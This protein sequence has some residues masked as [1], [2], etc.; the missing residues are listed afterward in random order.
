MSKAAVPMPGDLTR[1]AVRPV[2]KLN[3]NMLKVCINMGMIESKNMKPACMKMMNDTNNMDM[4]KPV[5]MNMGM[6][7]SKNMK[8]ACMK[9]IN[10]TNNMDMLK[11]VCM[12]MMNDSTNMDMLK[13]VCMKMMKENPF[14]KPMHDF[15]ISSNMPKDG[16][17]G[18]IAENGCL[19]NPNAKK[20]CQL[21]CAMKEQNMQ[22]SFNDKGHN[23]SNSKKA[24]M[25]LVNSGSKI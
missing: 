17:K 20:M 7:E 10:D 13:P 6:M 14:M 1:P 25:D 2:I 22:M 19:K 24:Y 16:C 21:S 3:D 11:P 12:K 18:L 9:M 8:P 4:I 15:N 23:I 5:C